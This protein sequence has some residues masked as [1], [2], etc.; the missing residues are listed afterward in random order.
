MKKALPKIRKGF[1]YKRSRHPSRTAACWASAPSSTNTIWTNFHLSRALRPPCVLPDRKS[2]ELFWPC[3]CSVPSVSATSLPVTLCPLF[4]KGG[5]SALSGTESFPLPKDS[6]SPSKNA[7]AA[8]PPWPAYH[9]SG[10]GSRR[11]AASSAM[12]RTAR[13]CTK[14]A[15]AIR[16]RDIA[17]TAQR[18][19]ASMW[20]VRRTTFFSVQDAAFT[21]GTFGARPHA[22]GSPEQ[23]PR[24]PCGAGLP[25][26]KPRPQ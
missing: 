5:D 14:T 25:C 3:S 4:S 2:A 19:A 17:S 6:T 10:C 9:D 7:P 18:P 16:E 23:M 15:S 26:P 21:T 11:A 12:T 22:E 20:P 1:F 13:A 24:P 8:L